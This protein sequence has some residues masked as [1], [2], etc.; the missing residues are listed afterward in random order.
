MYVGGTF[1]MYSHCEMMYCMIDKHWCY[2]VLKRLWR[3]KALWIISYQLWKISICYFML[4][5]I[6][7]NSYTIL[8]DMDFILFSKI[9][10][11]MSENVSITVKAE[12]SDSPLGKQATCCKIGG[13]A[14]NI[15]HNKLQFNNDVK[16]V[17]W[18]LKSLVS[19]LF[20]Q[21]L[22]AN[23]KENTR[24]PSQYKDRLSR[25]RDSHIKISQL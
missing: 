5:D 16:W 22:Q 24:A 9:E 19:W 12:I 2:P 8:V 6:G 4:T 1:V 13:G 20:V 7:C 25:Y 15:Y 17:S 23:S 14:L 10:Y 3:C 21:Q 11:D 18:H